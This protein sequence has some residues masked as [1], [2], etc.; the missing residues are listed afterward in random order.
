MFCRGIQRY[1]RDRVNACRAGSHDQFATSGR[2]LSKVIQGQIRR[3][4][5]ADQVD[6]H[7]Q[8]VR[9]RWK[10]VSLYVQRLTEIDSIQDTLEL[11]VK[12]V[13]Q[14]VAEL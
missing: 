3:P 1:F 14:T 11:C 2:V 7:D 10:D 4:Y 8:N 6:I 5:N 13:N 12:L 9:L